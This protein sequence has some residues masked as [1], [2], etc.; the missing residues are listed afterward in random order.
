[1]CSISNSKHKN[2]LPL[3]R[4]LVLVYK[5]VKKEAKHNSMPSPIQKTFPSRLNFR[6]SH[7][8]YNVIALSFLLMD[9]NIIV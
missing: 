2:S 1:M 4:D 5:V 9:T 7:R 8:A 6:E 3:K